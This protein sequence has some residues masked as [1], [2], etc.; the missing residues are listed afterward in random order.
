MGRRRLARSARTFLLWL[1]GGF[2]ACQ[3]VLA[4]AIDGWLP[5]VRD[6]EFAAKFERLQAR[7]AE[8][9]G[10]PLIV[11]LGSSRMAF[12]LDA[13]RLSGDGQGP[14]VFN[15]G[16]MGGG[17]LLDL[18]TLRR[19][20]DA[21]V[22]PDR[23]YVEVVPFMMAQRA[24]GLYEE[25]LLDGARLRAAEVWRLRQHYQQPFRLFEGWCLGRVL[26]CYRHQAELRDLCNPGAA[27]TGVVN[28]DEGL[29]G[30]GWCAR[31]D[32]PDAA[33]RRAGAEITRRL[34]A[35]ACGCGTFARE[36]VAA[37]E[38]LLELC[39]SARIAVTLVLLPEATAFQAFYTPEAREALAELL[40]HLESRWGVRTIDARTWVAD[41]DFS[42]THHLLAGGGRRFT[43]RLRRA[44][45]GPAVASR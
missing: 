32:T 39:G 30:Y 2:V 22:R 1:A 27:H 5:R 14:L 15:F 21:G 24:G 25:H 23:L 26:P 44:A 35:D 11:G 37:L 45:V 38:A 41:E 36:P 29:D 16:L 3:G 12:G 6:P 9:P 33:Q 10:R 13:G 43:E 17:P 31:Y 42:D 40:A 4:V 20:L 18:V 19:L 28:G 7:R 8:A 34:C